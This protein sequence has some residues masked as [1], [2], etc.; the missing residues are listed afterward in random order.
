MMK[1]RVDEI[2]DEADPERRLKL[3]RELRA[4]FQDRMKVL[5][6][7]TLADMSGDHINENAKR[8]IEQVFVKPIH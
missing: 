2:F 4:I 6:C 8:I 5:R 1:L 3:S 7:G